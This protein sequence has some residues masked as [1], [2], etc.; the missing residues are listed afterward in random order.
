M[1]DSPRIGQPEDCDSNPHL[2]IKFFF[3]FSTLFLVPAHVVCA[4]PFHLFE[5][6]RL[7]IAV[8]GFFTVEHGLNNLVTGG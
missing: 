3:C 5:A 7:R 2:G 8:H 1:V 4:I 6:S